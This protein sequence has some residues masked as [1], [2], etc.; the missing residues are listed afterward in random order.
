MASHLQGKGLAY[1]P[2]LTRKAAVSLKANCIQLQ[3]KYATEIVNHQ[4]P[5]PNFHRWF[6][7]LKKVKLIIE[8]LNI[9]KYFF[10]D[11]NKGKFPRFGTHE[12]AGPQEEAKK[13]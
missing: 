5:L 13:A 12:L 1:H 6:L 2:F 3:A 10:K 4:P 8:I 7:G 9:I 11:K